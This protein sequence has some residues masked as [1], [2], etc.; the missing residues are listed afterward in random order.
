MSLASNNK[1]NLTHLQRPTSAILK[2]ECASQSPGGRVRPQSAGPTPRA[3]EAAGLGL[4]P[5]TCLSNT[6]PG[7]ADA[8]GLETPL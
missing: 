7:D 2:L 3:T 6:F 4:G 1:A 5:G 8:A